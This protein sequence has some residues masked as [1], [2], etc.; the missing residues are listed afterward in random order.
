MIWDVGDVGTDLDW[1]CF[2][3]FQFW[4]C[5]GWM[6]PPMGFHGP[7]IRGFGSLSCEPS[8]PPRL[9]LGIYTHD[10]SM[11]MVY[12]PTFGLNSL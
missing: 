10:G 8:D 5:H 3:R 6:D 12:L 2:Q 7:A 9:M 1:C 4:R 11:G